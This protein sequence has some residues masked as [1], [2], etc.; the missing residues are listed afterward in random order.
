MTN[1]P[2]AECYGG[3]AML[4]VPMND[5]SDFE[6][7]MLRQNLTDVFR[8]L[9]NGTTIRVRQL[10]WSAQNDTDGIARGEG[11]GA[12]NGTSFKMETQIHVKWAWTALPSFLL[13]MTILS[14]GI[15]VRN[16]KRMGLE[17]WKSSPTALICSA[18]DPIG[19]DKATAGISVRL[20]RCDDD[21]S[22]SWKLLKRKNEH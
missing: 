3:T 17:A 19:M 1:I 13:V 12:A 5:S 14:T 4:P 2:V 9:A 20:G 11:I 18:R 21:C 10:D 6:E 22:D 16:T 8:S 15:T 7:P